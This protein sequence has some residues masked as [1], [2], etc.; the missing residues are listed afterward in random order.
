[1]PHR[2]T[3]R[4]CHDLTRKEPFLF[5]PPA[6]PSSA[7]PAPT[8]RFGKRR[9][10]PNYRAVQQRVRATDLADSGVANGVKKKLG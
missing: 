3:T 1:M 6:T 5:A 4:A 7:L 9:G 10:H 2:L 8:A